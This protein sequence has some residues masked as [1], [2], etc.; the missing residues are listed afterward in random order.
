MDRAEFI[1]EQVQKVAGCK[2]YLVGGSVRDMLLG[3]EPKDYDFATSCLPSAVESNVK[4]HG[5][6][7]YAIGKKYGTIGFK[8]QDETGKFQY[9]EVTTFRAE[10][11]EPGSRKPEV[12]FVT[13]LQDDLSRRDFTIN[14]IAFENDYIDPFGGRLDILEKKIKAVGEATDRFKEDPLRMLRA[15][16]FAAQLDF[17]ID[18]NMIGKIRK[19][20]DKILTISR[21][22]WVQEMDKLLLAPHWEKGIIVLHQTYLMKYMLPELELL[23]GSAR[24]IRELI[25][26]MTKEQL[27]SEATADSMWAEMLSHSGKGFVAVND[28]QDEEYGVFKN[29]EKIALEVARGIGLRLKFSNDRMAAIETKIKTNRGG[30]VPAQT[31]I[32]ITQRT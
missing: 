8:V 21:E 18:P 11:Y 17:E 30:H 27:S 2:C 19:M 25:E 6:R 31:Q 26:G 23:Y 5:R 20:S 24:A 16:R 10:Q 13:E 4:K 14:A 9:V 28:I 15:A 32:H 1:I 7:V 22:R 12:Q 29:H 3:R